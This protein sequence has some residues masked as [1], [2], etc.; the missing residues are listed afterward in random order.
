MNITVIIV[1]LF[2]VFSLIGGLIGYFKAGSMPSLMAGG[3]SGIILLLSAFGI[4]KEN[5]VAVYAAGIVALLLGGRFLIT[6][7]QKFK[8][9][10]DLLMVLFSAITLIVVIMHLLRK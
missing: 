9:M 5:Q 2:G 4:S 10:P 3:I 7:L 8:I 1:G 6:M